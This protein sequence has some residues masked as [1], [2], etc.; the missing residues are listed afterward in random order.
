MIKI[1][2]EMIIGGKAD[3]KPDSDFSE[4]QLSVGD[5]IE[6]EHTTD[7]AKAHEIAKDHLEEIPDYYT[8]LV[9][10][11]REAEKSA[12]LVSDGARFVANASDDVVLAYLAHRRANERKMKP[13]GTQKVAD[14]RMDHGDAVAAVREL[15]KDNDLTPEQQKLLDDKLG[16]VN[17]AMTAGHNV[18]H[19]GGL[20]RLKARTLLQNTGA[21]RLTGPVRYLLKGI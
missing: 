18:E 17:T 2:K 15:L 12:G 11:E 3:G 8:R 19:A 1:S 4:K 21:D 10:M 20:N 9:K 14:R 5:R 7:P 6:K 16:R 13:I